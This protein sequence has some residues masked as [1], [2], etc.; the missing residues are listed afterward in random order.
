MTSTN[1][2]LVGEDELNQYLA[3]VLERSKGSGLNGYDFYI[4][5]KKL[6]ELKKKDDS[7]KPLSAIEKH[8]IIPKF[9]GGSDAADNIVLLTVKEHI[10]A[11]WI[12]WKILGKKGDYTS[13]L[14]RIGDTEEALA[15]R[16]KMVLEARQKDKQ[17][18]KGFYSSVF[19]S[20]MGSRGGPKG[21]SSNSE[22][23]FKARQRVGQT[24]G[25]RTG[26]Q[27][28]SSSLY[29]FV[30]N[31]SIWAFSKKANMERRVNDRGPELFYLITPKEG[32]ADITRTLN[33][34]VPNSIPKEGIASMHK[35]VLGLRPQMYGWRIVDRLI[36]SEVGEG[37]KNFYIQNSN[38][39]LIFE[40]DFAINEGFE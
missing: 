26:I 23:Q 22:S 38:E 37:I 24:Y 14:F 20:T 27:N 1:K 31:F 30:S 12:R 33:A 21:G 9:D 34:F 2:Y 6:S 29:N 16:S 8:H 7:E 35:L 17:E 4:K 5:E 25:R 15:Y 32:F 28:Q 39:N 19:Q 3:D 10:I 13:F 40:E 18:G 11:H 36:R